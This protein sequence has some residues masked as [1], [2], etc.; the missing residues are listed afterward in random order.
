MTAESSG[1]I[2][3]DL[4]HDSGLVLPWGEDDNGTSPTSSGQPRTVCAVL[5]RGRNNEV[6]FRNRRLIVVAQRLV[7]FNEEP[8][9]ESKV[10]YCE[11]IS[12][13]MSASSLRHHVPNSGDQWRWQPTRHRRQ[14]GWGEL[15]ERL[16]LGT[17]FPAEC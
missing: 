13:R 4:G 6:G 10:S 15:S 2:P 3:A 7:T 8:P 16:E 1:K 14:V 11:R 5:Q 17:P 9:E 12:G